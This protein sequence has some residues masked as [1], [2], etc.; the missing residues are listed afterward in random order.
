MARVLRFAALALVAL[1][2]LGVGEGLGEWRPPEPGEPGPFGM[3][4]YTATETTRAAMLALREF[5]DTGNLRREVWV[6]PYRGSDSG[7]GSEDAPYQTLSKGAEQALSYT[8][9]KL[10][11]G[12][13]FSPFTFTMA[14]AGIAA[15]EEY[16]KGE[17][18]TWDGG[19][20]T[21]TALDWVPGSRILVLEMLTGTAPAAAAADTIVGTVSGA[22]VATDTLTD[23]I[24]TNA[25]SLLFPDCDDGDE[26]CI[27]FESTDPDEPVTINCSNT[28]AGAGQAVFRACEDPTDCDAATT[29]TGW[30]GVQNV[31]IDYCDT[32]N[33][34]V[35]DTAK[36]FVLN[37][38]GSR[39]SNTAAL[40]NNCYTPHDAGTMWVLNG[41][42]YDHL[43]PSGANGSPIAPVGTTKFGLMGGFYQVDAAG[44]AS[45]DVA[46]LSGTD[47]FVADVIFDANGEGMDAFQFSPTTNSEAGTLRGF[48]IVAAGAGASNAACKFRIGSGI[49][50]A[51]EDVDLYNLSCV[52]SGLGIFINH[53]AGLA[54]DALNLFVRGL[55][56][57]N[58]G[59]D[60]FQT[61]AAQDIDGTHLNISHVATDD[62]TQATDWRI[63]ATQYNT[64]ALAAADADVVA[65][66]WTFFTNHTELTSGSTPDLPWQNDGAT[67]TLADFGCHPESECWKAYDEAYTV[68]LQSTL[69]I[70]AFVLGREV[71][72]FRLGGTDGNLGAR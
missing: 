6:D 47:H 41:G 66:G 49:S 21:G 36:M 26:L 18:L 20:S 59:N 13:V 27:L 42:C 57:A 15:G 39:V 65:A 19:A 16:F 22:S 1:G 7:N 2:A 31:V 52:D 68:T 3:D 9:V 32:D 43:I 71:R 64:V 56:M 62:L 48:N 69:Y 28:N 35:E 4:G 14:A 34:D 37:S 5:Q 29:A 61:L 17:P 58:I 40:N 50:A 67:V 63:N 25:A 70:P 8:R 30:V 38:P 45:S 72:A 10:K 54:N 46:V 60:N 51:T 53:D 23:T 24:G 11:G 55:V 12:T 44:G 33:F